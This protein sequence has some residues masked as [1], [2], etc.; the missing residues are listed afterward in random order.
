MKKQNTI[1][2]IDRHRQFV[3]FLAVV[4]SSI[5]AVECFKLSMLERNYP[6]RITLKNGKGSECSVVLS[7]GEVAEGG[8]VGRRAI[9]VRCWL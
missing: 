8:W 1:V 6:I 7:F 5:V 4:E 3:C 9:V 2:V